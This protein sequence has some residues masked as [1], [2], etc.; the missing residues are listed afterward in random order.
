MLVVTLPAVPVEQR[1]AA[2]ADVCEAPLAAPHVPLTTA[3]QVPEGVPHVLPV[4]LAVAEPVVLAAVEAVEALV[5]PLVLWAKVAEQPPPHD[6][7]AAGQARLAVQLA[8]V[9]LP[10]PL[11]VH[12]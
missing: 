11:H 10:V 12:V 6:K 2:G 9:P 3:A 5:V 7:L 1:L 8:L 4:Q